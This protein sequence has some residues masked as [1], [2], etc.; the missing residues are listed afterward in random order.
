M[1]VIL[2]KL[3][4]SFKYTVNHYPIAVSEPILLHLERR[5]NIYNTDSNR[6]IRFCEQRS[7][8]NNDDL[9][10]K[11]YGIYLINIPNERDFSELP[12]V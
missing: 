11:L 3:H 8:Y 2:I 9:W 6:N 10:P 1:K 5:P 12:V 7:K 4:P